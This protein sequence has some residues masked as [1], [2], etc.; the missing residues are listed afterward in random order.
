MIKRIFLF[1]FLFFSLVY[2][3]S[4][5]A[6][7]HL[8]LTEIGNTFKKAFIEIYNPTDRTVSL[9]DY[10]LTNAPNYYLV[11]DGT[12]TAASGDFLAPFPAGFTIAPG[13]VVVVAFEGLKFE[14]E[15]GFKPDFELFSDDFT[16]VPNLPFQGDDL[17]KFSS[18]D[19]IMLF[20]WDGGSALVKDADYLAWKTNTGAGVDK[21]GITVSGETYLADTPVADQKFVAYSS[22]MERFGPV[23]IGET[24]S[25]GNGITGHDE[26]S[27][28]MAE[29]WQTGNEANPGVF[30][31]AG[32]GEF[33]FV[34]PVLSGN[35]SNQS[36]TLKFTAPKYFHLEG[37]RIVIP[38]GE[39]G[40][41][42]SQTASDVS[43]S[44][45]V[46]ADPP[47]VSVDADTI[48]IT[49]G[50]FSNEQTGEIEI[51]SLSTPD[52]A[53]SLYF[54]VSTRGRPEESYADISQFP[55]LS[56]I[57][58][59]VEIADI[60][61]NYSFYSG[62]KVTVNGIVTIG[63]NTIQTGRTNVY[64]Q[65]NSGRGINI[66][67]FTEYTG[68]VRGTRY[69]ITGTVGEYNSV[70]Q[71]SPTGLN[72]ISAGNDLPAAQELTTG[73]ANDFDEYDG[74]WVH[75]KG[76]VKSYSEAGGGAN[77][78][79]DDGSGA[80]LVRV[81]GS[82]GINTSKVRLGDTLDVHGII[83]T[84]AGTAQLLPSLQEDF[85]ITRPGVPGDG[86]GSLVLSSSPVLPS[87][88][89]FDLQLTFTAED[90]PLG[91]IAVYPSAGIIYDLANV[92]LDIQS[93]VE[94]LSRNGFLIKTDG[95]A[96]H[97]SFSITITGASL[98][99][100]MAVQK[101][102]NDAASENI[103]TLNTDMNQI[104]PFFAYS[105]VGGEGSIIQGVDGFVSAHTGSGNRY[106][107]ADIQNH[108]SYF[109]GASVTVR[110][111]MTISAGTLRTDMTS[112]YLQD[113]SGRGVNIYNRNLNSDLRRGR[114]V[115]LSG[116]I[117]DYNGVTEI[118]YSSASLTADTNA[119]VPVPLKL[120]V[121]ETNEFDELDGTYIE[122]RGLVKEAP[123][124]VGGGDNVILGDHTG[125]ITVRVWNTTG[126][127][128]AAN[129]LDSLIV[130]G[131]LSLYRESVQITPSEGD[132]Y[133]V[134]D[135]PAPPLALK[136]PA[137]PF[138]PQYGETFKI[139]FGTGN[140]GSHVRLKLFDMAGR[141]VMTVLDEDF[142]N[143]Y[144]EWDGRDH[145]GDLIPPGVYILHMEV[146]INETGQKET[147]IVPVV[148]GTKLN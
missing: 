126:L 130:K 137:H 100:R 22:T 36:V 85:I 9:D 69:V 1:F 18:P 16:D 41:S 84:Y 46:F 122:L 74:T 7:D 35:V 148:I 45:E 79:I 48:T 25:G 43:L 76:I 119:F 49:G 145:R 120:S 128:T 105:A 2:N 64:I 83:G 114:E 96:A 88:G 142:F 97:A 112:A 42:W 67:S 70:T 110:G 133:I 54:Q 143:N 44:G 89:T 29:A 34:D 139:E 56:V 24:V 82:T 118:S 61:R 3:G 103:D 60:Q 99:S 23:E 68:M 113:E 92:S 17:N 66:S 39:S 53:V 55:K 141:L 19:F 51:S 115:I 38:G 124:N 50:D 135:A 94:A 121:A 59:L 11:T 127:L 109:N 90:Y 129:V 131:V 15:Y 71:I 93:T 26:T 78:S 30:S 102:I 6:Q 87:S 10:Y 27:E 144:F 63:I 52:T 37:L 86:T 73:R 5:S 123:Y 13:S 138:A 117:T 106:L 40:L 140:K 80:L 28:D 136:V 81:W 107:I 116:S 95:L 147:R 101:Y 14:S 31:A 134:K 72:L 20:F 75:A 104:F 12:F 33:G 111:R 125:F 77:I 47:S 91:K 8:I 62:K 146:K 57:K 58:E 21:S 4:L 65:D 108:F 32:K 98:V 132:D